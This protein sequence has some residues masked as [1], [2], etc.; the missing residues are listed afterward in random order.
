MDPHDTTTKEDVAGLKVTTAL[1]QEDIKE[2]K[3]NQKVM[4][5]FVA[6]QRAGRKVIWMIFGAA[7]AIT[8][9]AK[10]FGQLFTSFFNR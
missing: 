9:I 6:E 8:A 4:L 10:D 3:D 5:E 2:I 1:M 7:A